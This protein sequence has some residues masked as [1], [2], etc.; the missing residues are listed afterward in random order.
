MAEKYSIIY[1]YHIFFSHSLVDGHL[2][3]FHIL[4]IANGAA[5]KIGVHVPFWIMIFSGYML[6]SGIAESHGSFIFS[7][8]RNLHTIVHSGCVNLH[9]HQ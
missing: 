9:S 4:A 8:L 6:R 3:H 1:T 2:G 5:I 7:F